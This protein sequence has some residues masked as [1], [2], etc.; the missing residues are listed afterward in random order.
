MGSSPVVL[1]SLSLSLPVFVSLFVSLS[2]PLL[3]ALLALSVARST[4][5]AESCA[6]PPVRRR[7]RDRA[8]GSA[9]RIGAA[10][11]FGAPSR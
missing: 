4:A 6:A 1:L 2:V 11:S 5:N 8:A 7:P 9:A 10:A 3:W